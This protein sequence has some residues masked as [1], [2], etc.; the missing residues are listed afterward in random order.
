MR[1]LDNLKHIH[2]YII[3]RT[4]TKIGQ[5]FY[6]NNTQV[7]CHNYNYNNMFKIGNESDETYYVYLL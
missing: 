3:K 2:L 5:H 7:I 4:Y 6:K 1:I